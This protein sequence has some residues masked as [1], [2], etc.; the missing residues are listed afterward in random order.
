MKRVCDEC[1]AMVDL[2][3]FEEVVRHKTRGHR[4]PE[5]SR[6]DEGSFEESP[7]ETVHFIKCSECGQAYDRRELAEVVHHSQH[8]HQPL[9]RSG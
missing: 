1:G 9:A 6:N 7:E 3:D 2:S 4:R 5:V 8:G